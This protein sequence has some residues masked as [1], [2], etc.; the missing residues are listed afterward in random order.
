MYGI[1]GSKLKCSRKPFVDILFF[2]HRLKC[3]QSSF[4]NNSIYLSVYDEIKN[5]PKSTLGTFQYIVS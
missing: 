3:S 2:A 1:E 5:V 4:G